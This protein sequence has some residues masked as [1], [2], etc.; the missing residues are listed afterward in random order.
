MVVA[1]LAPTLN[2][3]L[4]TPRTVRQWHLVSGSPP[5]AHGPTG[6]KLFTTTLLAPRPTVAI[7]ATDS[8]SWAVAGH[9]GLAGDRFFSIN[10]PLD[11]DGFGFPVL[12]P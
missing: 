1:T 3:T 6:V 4:Q 7:V 2:P 5:S 8:A 10:A 12:N 9:K 11:K